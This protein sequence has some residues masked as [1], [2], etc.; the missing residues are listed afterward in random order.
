MNLHQLDISI[1]HMLLLQL[2][3]LFKAKGSLKDMRTGEHYQMQDAPFLGGGEV[4]CSIDG[5]LGPPCLDS[6]WHH[7]WAESGLAGRWKM[8]GS[9]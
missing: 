6:G 8:F 4:H 5:G 9:L 1:I 3:V 2:I 7:V